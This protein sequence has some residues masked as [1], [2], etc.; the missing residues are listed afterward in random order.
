MHELINMI[1]LDNYD[2]V[3]IYYASQENYIIKIYTLKND[4]YELLQIINDYRN[5][6]NEK[7]ERAFT[8]IM[9]YKTIRYVIKDVKKLSN[10]R[11][12]TISNH[13][14]KIYS[15]DKDSKYSLSFISK[16]ESHDF[17]NNIYVMNENELIIIYDT[18]NRP[19]LRWGNYIFEI[20]KFDI[21]KNSISKTIFSKKENEN[22]QYHYSNFIILKKKYLIII[23]AEIFYIID[24]IEGSKKSVS[25]SLSKWKYNNLTRIYNFESTNDDIFLVIQYK[26][27]SVIQFND[28]LNTLKI[29]GK[30]EYNPMYIDISDSFYVKNNYEC[31]LKKI[32]NDFYICANGF[33]NFY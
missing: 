19:K 4:K 21:E 6:F 14:F 20:D 16:N 25:L 7:R 1:E 3:L 27:F 26:Q 10:N 5:G 17:I 30:F 24:I 29:I 12:M 9:R 11:F 2:L 13:G 18:D 28:C 31:Y 15:K 33:I 32:K 22:K 23:L 8:F